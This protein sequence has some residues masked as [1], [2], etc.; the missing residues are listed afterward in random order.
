[1]RRRRRLGDGLA[2]SA[3]ELLAHALDDLPAPRLAFERLRHDLAKLAQPRP[4]APA[5]DARRGLDDALDRKIVGQLA[6]TAGSAL[7][8]SP[9]RPRHFGAR[10]FLRLGLLQILDRELE[11]LG[12]ELAA[13]RRLSETLAARPGELKLQPL[14][15]ENAGLGFAARGGKQLALRQDHRMGARQIAGK[16]VGRRS[17]APVTPPT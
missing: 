16:T 2:V 4:A 13:L 7:L 12:D 1:M 9:G 17:T 6:R 14:D 15:L 8:L 10:L 11:L 5:A 3:G